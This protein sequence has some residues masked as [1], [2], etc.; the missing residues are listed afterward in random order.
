MMIPVYLFSL[1]ALAADP[2]QSDNSGDV[3]VPQHVSEEE[4]T[5]P[6]TES[7][8]PKT[9]SPDTQKPNS[10]AT[11]K[12]TDPNSNLDRDAQPATE[13]SKTETNQA[14]Q[15]PET[16]STE[17]ASSEADS[18]PDVPANEPPS[19]QSPF[20]PVLIYS[21]P[22]NYPASALESGVSGTVLLEIDV[23]EDGTVTGARAVEADREDFASE[24]VIN[25]RSFRFEPMLGPEGVP[26]PFQ[27]RYQTVFEATKAAP[28]SIEGRVREAGPR[29]LIGNAEILALGPN[30]ERIL[31][32]TDSNGTFRVSGLE[33][34][35]WNVRVSAPGHVGEALTVD[36]EDNAISSI[37]AYLVR[38]EVRTGTAIN[39][40]LV[41]TALAPQTEVTER[42]LSAEDVRYLPGTGGDVVKV[43]QN[44]PGIARPPLGTGNLRIRGTAP[45]DS[46]YFI[47]GGRIPIVFHFSGLTTVLSSDLLKEV[48]FLPGSYSVQY[49]RA[50]GGLV[51][52][53]TKQTL[54]ERSNG[55][56][57]VDVF[58]A[59]L[60]AEQTIGENDAITVSARRSYAD[61]VLNPILNKGTLTVQAP[62]YYDAQVRWSKKFD[63]GWNDMLFLLSDDRF[64]FL[65]Q[66]DDET[67]LAG[68]AT[69]FQKFRW[70]H[71]RD[72]GDDR[73]VEA[74]LVVGPEKQFFENDNTSEAYEQE[75]RVSTRLQLAQETGTDRSFGWMIGTDPNFNRSSFLYDI[76]RPP[77]RT[78]SSDR[79]APKES[80]EF[81]I[82]QPSL[83]GELTLK[84]GELTLFPGLRSDLQM[85][86]DTS[87][88]SIDPRIRALWSI[89]DGTVIKGGAGRHSQA[90]TPRQLSPSSDGNPDLKAEA[91]YQFSAGFEQFITNWLT[92]DLTGFYHH[93]DSLVVGREDRFAFYSG[94]P[95]T[96]PFDT[97]PY[98]NDGT[99]RTFG[100]ELLATIDAEN[101]SGFL[102]A[103]VS[104]SD[105][106]KRPGDERTLF[107]YDQP[108][109]INALVSR[110]LPKR[111][112][113]GSRLRYGSGNPY[114]PVT[115]RIYN[116][117]RR[118][119]IPVYGE[120]DSGRLPPFFSLDLRID[121]DY[122]FKK[123]TLTTYLDIQNAT[124]SKNVETQGYSYDYTEE[125]PILSN[126]PLP[127]FGLRGEW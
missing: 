28:V 56:L 80:G 7:L 30:G 47:D 87:V 46:L 37:D 78:V 110:K 126:P 51:D 101:T 75:M 63:N 106:I 109:V 107:E 71:T 105:R 38:D 92:L 34:G 84:K 32:T 122:V 19:S 112:R 99:G 54:P 42:T 121:K 36:V 100:L 64:R 124:Y 17:P 79:T 24:A 88:F 57:S 26:V 45:E 23:G 96:G 118:E 33:S 73:N 82:W 1:C 52:L 8:P 119:F 91:A 89:G 98:A 53:R 61:A 9:P 29:R 12:P 66:G 15:G 83:Y 67:V 127:A 81:D 44:L 93:L 11:E 102:A 104:R 90:P 25:A 49:G 113:I 40:E 21:P 123:W 60:F 31:A 2:E 20:I 35:Q 77:E 117:D 27:L 62:R 10:T 74:S 65:G 41:V 120:R 111:W 94:P 115:N 70:L 95:P 48:A 3:A 76:A 18:D 85:V 97:E 43:I 5:P 103:T 50:L 16:N 68:F 39:E 114:T 69:Q 55:N 116:H 6:E 22:P 4:K 13:P 125:E 58:Q 14:A 59:A 86:G 72:L 108:L